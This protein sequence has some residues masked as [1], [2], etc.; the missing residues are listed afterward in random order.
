MS[1]DRFEEQIWEVRLVLALEALAETQESY[2]EEFWKTNGFP[3]QAIFNGRDETPY[4]AEDLA[5]L[6]ETAGLP[7]HNGSED[8]FKPLRIALAHV[9]D[10]MRLHPSLICASRTVFGCDGLQVGILNGSS[11]TSLSRII[12]GQMVRRDI[13]SKKSFRGP[14]AE[15]NSILQ[16]SRGKRTHPLPCQLDLGY[17]IALFHGAGVQDTVDLGGG[18]SMMPYSQLYEYVDNEW[19]E[20][21]APDQLRNRNWLSVFAIVH[22]FH[23]KP[24]IRPPNYHRDD[25][26]RSP[27]AKFDRWTSEFANLLAVSTG[28]PIRWM[29]TI[30]ECVPRAAS[31]LLGKVHDRG[32]ARLGRSIGHLFDPF[33]QVEPVDL[34]LV[35]HFRRHFSK[36]DD[37]A[38]AELAPVIHRLA[39]AVARDGAYASEDRVLDVAV[40][41][42]RLFKPSGRTISLDLQNTIS[43]FLGSCEEEKVQIRNNV[44]HFYDVRS[45]IIHGPIDSKK[46][47]LR[48]ETRE[49]FENG[50]ELAR[51][52]LMRQ[53]ERV[54]PSGSFAAK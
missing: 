51:V 20:D 47:R 24:E 19:L 40:S 8:H 28:K 25:F 42:E 37:T 34:E 26:S 31:D 50:F 35:K 7:K 49:A 23:W 4:P 38:Y 54:P 1:T 2:L 29:M 41:L 3:T 11:L 30:D 33:K 21:V 15:L 16:L 36:I 18:Y 22:Q 43:D 13:S 27:P 39:E 32:S 53:L 44:K 17:N 46:K 52:S 14:I 6:Y 10:V 45:A 12:V 48:R 9:R 5:R